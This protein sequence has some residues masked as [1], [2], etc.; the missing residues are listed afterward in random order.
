[1]KVPGNKL[2]SVL[3]ITD[4][5]FIRRKHTLAAVDATLTHG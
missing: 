1:M 4:I 5:N 2:R 3:G